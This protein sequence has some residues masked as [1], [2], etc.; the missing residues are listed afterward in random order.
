MMPY[1]SVTPHRLYFKGIPFSY[2]SQYEKT[3]QT[4]GK[5]IGY[6]LGSVFVT[7]LALLYFKFSFD[8]LH[9][10]PKIFCGILIGAFL[11]SFVAGLTLTSVMGLGILS[12]IQITDV[13]IM[14]YLLSIAF[15]VKYSIHIIAA[16]LRVDLSEDLALC[17]VKTTMSF[18]QLPL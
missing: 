12:G 1:N 2:W 4:L 3:M 16:W 11:V 18:L 8:R 9:E 17:R 6:C 14:T 10:R 5:T 13:S 7:T 15:S